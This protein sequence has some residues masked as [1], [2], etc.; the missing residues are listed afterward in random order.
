MNISF[1]KCTLNDLDMLHQIS[2]I[3]FIAAFEKLNS[4]EDFHNYM[5]SAF[6]KETIKTQLLNRNSS[7]YFTYLNRSLIGYFKLNAKDAQIEQFE[8]PSIELE[9]IYVLEAFQGKQIGKEM[10]FKSIDIAKSKGVSFIWLGVW[11]ENTAAVRF[12]ERFGFK[13]FGSHPYYI[14][15]DKQTDWLMKLNLV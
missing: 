11:Q 1:I 14:G 4:P 8:Q 12:Y 9:R 13:I 3:T 2:R 6:S 5:D 10:L 7:F 15:K